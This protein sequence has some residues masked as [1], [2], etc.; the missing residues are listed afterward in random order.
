MKGSA[1]EMGWVEKREEKERRLIL[2]GKFGWTWLVLG[3]VRLSI[4]CIL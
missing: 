4:V 2:L 3:G 1:S